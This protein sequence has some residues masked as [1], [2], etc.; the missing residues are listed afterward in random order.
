MT[1]L[2]AVYKSKKK[3]VAKKRRY[4]DGEKSLKMNEVKNITIA[5]KCQPQEN[6][7]LRFLYF[8]NKR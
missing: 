4:Q 1:G 8:F 5:L 2:T 3:V 6:I 7:C